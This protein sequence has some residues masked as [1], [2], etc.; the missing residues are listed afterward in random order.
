MKIA[1]GCD[2]GGFQLKAEVTRLL[3]EMGVEYHDFGCFSQESVD[4]PDYAEKVA[5]AVARGEYPLGIL[6]CGT[7]LGVSIAA[8]KVKGIRAVVCHDTFSARMS[9]EHNDANILA[10]GGRVVGPDLAREVARTFLTGKFSGDA[11]HGRRVAKITAIEAGSC[12][13]EA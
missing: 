13:T 9:R 4:Y 2:H 1:I 7:G 5:R 8:N 10:M 3:V 6:L 11:R 12:S